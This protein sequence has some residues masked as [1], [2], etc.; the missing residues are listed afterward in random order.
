M[1]CSAVLGAGLH[2]GPG[3]GPPEGGACEH[4]HVKLKD[5]D[6]S[7]VAVGLEAGHLLR[8]VPVYCVVT[9]QGVALQGRGR[10]G[11][12]RG[13]LFGCKDL[14]F[15]DGTGIQRRPGTRFTDKTLGFHGWIARASK[16]PPSSFGE[17]REKRSEVM[18]D[19]NRKPPTCARGLD[20]VMCPRGATFQLRQSSRHD[21]FL[22][23][24]LG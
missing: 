12:K 19:N 9:W 21:S 16:E 17:D 2:W 14:E 20:G 3:S 8:V 24:E 1:V 7:Q 23:E 22:R 6:E 13:H 10:N 11:Q 5:A 15:W 4:G 18:K